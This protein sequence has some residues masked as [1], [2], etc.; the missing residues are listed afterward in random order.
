VSRK[1]SKKKK[2]TKMPAAS[3]VLAAA[4]PI[5][6]S[7]AIQGPQFLRIVS[8]TTGI[9][10]FFLL[11]YVLLSRTVEAI[12]SFTVILAAERK[13]VCVIVQQADP[14]EWEVQLAETLCRSHS[15]AS[16]VAPRIISVK[17]QTALSV[18]FLCLAVRKCRAVLA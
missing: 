11:P 3:W 10:L 9:I 18:T 2:R 16:G 5:L 13:T 15:Q 4:L 1:E 8:V 6:N 14:Q 17:L 7:D 12:W